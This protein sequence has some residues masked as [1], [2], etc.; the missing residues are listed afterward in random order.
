MPEPPSVSEAETGRH[1]LARDRTYGSS[2][3][4]GVH[5][6]SVRGAEGTNACCLEKVEKGKYIHSILPSK[7][8]R[9]CPVVVVRE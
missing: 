3:R 9:A 1:V 2:K 7:V 8:A 6:S 4:R 5:A